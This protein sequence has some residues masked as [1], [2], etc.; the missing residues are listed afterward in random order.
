MGAIDWPTAEAAAIAWASGATELPAFWA[1][2]RNQRPDPP[3]VLLMP[4]QFVPVGREEVQQAYDVAQPLGEEIAVTTTMRWN[5][6]LSVTVFCKQADVTGT[7][8]PHALLLDA[9]T[10]ICQQDVQDAL[11]A[12]GLGF[13]SFTTVLPD[14]ELFQSVWVPTVVGL[15]DFDFVTS[16]TKRIGYMTAARLV[17]SSPSSTT[18]IA[19]TEEP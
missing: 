11:K 7:V 12:A 1:H 13:K 17:G 5:M 6:T 19:L 10:D 9:L 16:R 3:Y 18:T 2:Q 15:V 14:A 4:T 8:S